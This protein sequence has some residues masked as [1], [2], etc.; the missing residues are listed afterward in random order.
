MSLLLT[1]ASPTNSGPVIPAFEDFVASW[2]LFNLNPVGYS[3][4]QAFE[5]DNED[6]PLFLTNSPY[7][8][9]YSVVTNFDVLDLFDQSTENNNFVDGTN[10]P[11]LILTSPTVVAGAGTAEA[12][13]TLTYFGLTN[14]RYSAVY[15]GS[16]DVESAGVYWTSSEWRIIGSLPFRY[17]STEDVPYPWEVTTWTLDT[18]SLPVPTVTQGTPQTAIIGFDGVDDQLVTTENVFAGGSQQGTIYCLFYYD[19]S[20]APL[21]VTNAI[22]INENVGIYTSGGQLFGFAKSNVFDNSKIETLTVGWHFVAFGF[23]TTQAI[24]AN[25]T[26][27]Y[28]DGVLASPINSDDLADALLGDNLGYMGIDADG[29]KGP[30]QLLGIA[31]KN[32]LDTPEQ[33][34]AMR[35]WVESIP[36]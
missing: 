21:F 13:G 30:Y 29:N 23:D 4:G 15:E 2:G 16:G 27:M 22:N 28:V 25:Q 19:N 31:V 3:G 1:L 12:N 20:D 18:G 24:A 33:M 26:V 14:G 9:D 5:N 10:N 34:E 7:L 11:S 35:L 36:K 32:V 6:S 8:P 17:S